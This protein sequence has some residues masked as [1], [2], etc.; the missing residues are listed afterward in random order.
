MVEVV[1]QTTCVAREQ[2]AKNTLMG[3]GGGG[4]VKCVCVCVGVAGEGVVDSWLC[5]VVR[6]PLYPGRCQDAPCVCVCV[7]G[8]GGGV[9]NEKSAFDSWL[10]AVA[11]TRSTQA[12]VRTRRVQSAARGEAHGLQRCP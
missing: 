6:T 7:C 8:G 5:A 12:A 4:G 3:G 9:E 10:C 1:L 11:L 2:M